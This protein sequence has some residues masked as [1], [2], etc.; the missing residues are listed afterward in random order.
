MTIIK[1]LES[2]MDF[3]MLFS[4]P[5][6]HW[7]KEV[8]EKHKVNICNVA[9]TMGISGSYLGKILNGYVRATQKNEAKLR[10]V[11]EHLEAVEQDVNEHLR[12]HGLLDDV[13]MEKIV[14]PY[15]N[16]FINCAI[17]RKCLGEIRKA[18]IRKGTVYLCAECAAKKISPDEVRW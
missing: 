17:C 2:E 5:E 10:A 9:Q 6:P 4:I 3:T 14:K 12:E 11:V 15:P 18:E 13:P 1:K 7:A 16:I 8:F